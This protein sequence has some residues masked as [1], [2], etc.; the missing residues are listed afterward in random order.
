MI[1]SSVSEGKKGD[2][3]K[4]GEMPPPKDERISGRRMETLSVFKKTIGRIVFMPYYYQQ[5]LRLHNEFLRNSA[6][7]HSHGAGM[8]KIWAQ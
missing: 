4:G 2:D 8:R 7:Q 3:I 5:F 6:M 1:A